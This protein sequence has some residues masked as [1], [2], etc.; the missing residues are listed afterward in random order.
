MG[1]PLYVICCFPLVAFNILS[2][3]SILITLTTMCL[4][5]F[6]Y[7]FILS[8]TLCASWTWSTISFPYYRCFQLLSLQIF[9]WVLSF[10]SLLLGPIW[11][12]CFYIYCCPYF[13]SFLIL[14][15][16]AVISVMSSS[17][18]IHYSASVILLIPSSIFFISVYT[19]I[20]IYVCL[21]VYIYVYIWLLWAAGRILLLNERVN[22]CPLQ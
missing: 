13:F 16:V 12:E 2:L 18:L 5:V 10:S 21:Y 20:C 22:P 15:S 3:S 8:E 4:G 19:Y 7:G 9:S 1:V 17:S 6:L 14:C 11:Y